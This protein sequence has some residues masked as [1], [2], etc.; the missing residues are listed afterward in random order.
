MPPTTEVFI[1]IDV[2][3]RQLDLAI[4]G[5]AKGWRV[6]N[7]EGGI[8]ATVARLRELAPTRIV[9]EATGGYEFAVAS[10]LLAAGLPAGIVNPRQVRDFARGRNLLA[11]TDQLDAR[12]LA[13]F[14]A[15]MTTPLRP[16]PS[17]EV[18]ALQGIV[19]RRRQL[20][21]LLVAE[22]NR[23]EHASAPV[24][25]HI[26]AH[27]AWLHEDLAALDA[28]AVAAV[29]ASPAWQ[30][31]VSWL[32]SVPGVGN[33]VATTL[34]SGVPELGQLS[35]KQ[36]AALVGVAPFNRDSG[37]MRGKRMVWGGRAQVRAVL[38]M[39][40]LVATRCNPAIRVFYQRL[41]G[42]GKTKKLALTACMH[43]LLTILNALMREHTSWDASR[44]PAA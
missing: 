34:L 19:A 41:L 29:K 40:A 9:L 36:V 4:E 23:L 27:I 20:I 30:E 15:A 6:S 25:L 11:K 22:Q 44:Q 32:I 21:G 13:A 18:R 16:L 28:E 5:K 12:I 2:C 38:Y 14:A 8:A 35:G 31:Q 10:A 39:A 17:A 26:R 43:K 33:T 24:A 3:K 1:G 7:D 37:S 42:T